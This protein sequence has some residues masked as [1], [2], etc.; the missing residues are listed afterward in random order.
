MSRLTIDETDDALVSERVESFGGGID[1]YRRSTLI[2]PDQSQFGNN[3]LIRDNYEFWTRPGADKLFTAPN[4]NRLRGLVYYDTPTAN[5][6]IHSQGGHLYK[7]DGANDTILSG[8]TPADVAIEMAQGVNLLLITDGANNMQTYNGVT[9]TDCGS[10]P[11]DPPKN[12]TILC[13][14]T[15]RMFAAGHPTFND[16][17]WVS[18]RLAFGSGQWDTTLRSFRIGGGEGDPIVAMASMQDFVLCVLKGN[19]IHLVYTDPTAEPTNFQDSQ[20]TQPMPTGIGCVG[21][22][23]WVTIGNDLMFYSQDG[24]RSVQRMVAA[25][26]QYQLSPPVSQPIQPYIDRVNK[27]AWST[28][29]AV[30]RFELCMFFVP[31]DSATSPNTVLVYNTRL[32]KWLGIWTGWTG[33]CAVETFFTNNASQLVIGDSAGLV[34][35][36]KDL[37]SRTDDT[38]YTDNGIPYATQLWTRSF[39]CGD[40][41]SPKYAYNAILRFSAGNATVNLSLIT[42]NAQAQTWSATF[43]PSGDILG[44][45]T[46]PFLLSST[47]PSVV[48][49]SLLGLPEWN[50][51][52][53][54]IETSS[55]WFGCRNVT[56]NAMMN[57]LNEFPS[58]E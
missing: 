48:V 49:Q 14:H 38:T 57:A 43:Q 21:K 47:K 18:N 28:I 36:W 37:A 34:N 58:Q 10:T 26:G 40:P 41:I 32:Q 15:G 25:A 23:A 11:A 46:L 17:V 1:A 30:K 19:V 51:A 24:V 50:E 8:F 35:Q 44:V 56:L 4:S 3:V 2:D 12:C 53:L 16:T 6:L 5:Q 55:G 54:T 31:L 39:L 13:Y 42:D 7:F 9:F 29:F 27:S 45:G 33:T 52:Y 20:A 22:K